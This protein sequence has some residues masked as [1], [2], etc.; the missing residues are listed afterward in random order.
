LLVGPS[1]GRGRRDGQF[2]HRTAGAFDAAAAIAAGTDL[3]GGLLL[4]PARL[5]RV[6]SQTA[7]GIGTFLDDLVS[8]TAGRA[9]DLLETTER[10]EVTEV[11]GW[12]L[13]RRFEASLAGP[14]L[15]HHA[16]V[17]LLEAANAG[18]RVAAGL[19]RPAV[20]A[21]WAALEKAAFEHEAELAALP[22]GTPI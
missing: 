20:R 8:A 4:A 17:A 12:T 13:L 6:V 15:H 18:P 19:Q 9:L 7:A 16:R 10:T 14:E 5:N 1:G 22:L 3:V 21:R 2:D 11:I